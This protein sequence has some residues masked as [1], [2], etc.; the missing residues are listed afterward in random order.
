MQLWLRAD[1]GVVSRDGKVSRW[2]DESGSG[3]DA[4]MEHGP[5]QPSLQRG[6]LNDNPAVHFDGSQSLYLQSPVGPTAFTV[7]VVGKNN[8]TEAFSMILGPGGNEANNQLRWENGTDVLAVGTG[9]GLPIVTTPIGDTRTWHLLTLHYDGETLSLSKNGKPV[10]SHAFSTHGPWTF[11]QVGGYY[12][13]YFAKADLAEVIVY[14]AALPGGERE[15]VES[16][17]KSKYRL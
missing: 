17:L 13:Q 9:N 11:A 10:G 12:S 4:I 14:D 15:A 7:F 2:K 8:E 5:R 3:H 1:S 6:A 16:Y